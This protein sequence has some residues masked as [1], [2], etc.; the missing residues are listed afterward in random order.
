[1]GKILNHK[2]IQYLCINK[3]CG[4]HCYKNV[5]TGNY[6]LKCFDCQSLSDEEVKKT[7]IHFQT[8]KFRRSQSKNYKEATLLKK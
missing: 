2:Q 4:N 6:E 1:M 7:K 3:N 5:N 8:E